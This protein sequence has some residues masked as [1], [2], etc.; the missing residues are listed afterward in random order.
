MHRPPPPR[1]TR[2]PLAASW[3]PVQRDRGSQEGAGAPDSHESRSDESYERP[4][5]ASPTSAAMPRESYEG[6]S[7]E[8]HEVAQPPSRRSEAKPSE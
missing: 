7:P 3:D 4:Q 2:R 1:G 8:S 5:A 6:R